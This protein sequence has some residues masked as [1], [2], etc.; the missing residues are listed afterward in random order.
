MAEKFEESWRAVHNLLAMI[1]GLGD[2]KHVLQDAKEAHAWLE[3]A[4]KEALSAAQSAL[5]SAREE[6]NR[7]EGRLRALETAVEEKQAE[8]DAEVEAYKAERQGDLAELSE[9]YD[10]T[11]RELREKIKESE[12]YLMKCAADVEKATAEKSQ[13]LADIDAEVTLYRETLAT[14]K[15]EVLEA[16]SGLVEE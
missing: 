3:G 13:R 4:G 9:I 15:Q 14:V 5:Q 10:A 7:A 1:S 11:E 2:L 16:L 8:V 6:L 12:S